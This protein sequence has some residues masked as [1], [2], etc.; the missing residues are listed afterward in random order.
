MPYELSVYASRYPSS[1]RVCFGLTQSHIE[2]DGYDYATVFLCHF[3]FQQRVG[4][5]IGMLVRPSIS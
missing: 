2:L 1:G 5:G 3:P 4:I